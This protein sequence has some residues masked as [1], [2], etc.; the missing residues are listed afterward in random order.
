MRFDAA[1]RLRKRTWGHLT[2]PRALHERWSHLPW[3][4]LT[5]P[6]VSMIAH[7]RVFNVTYVG[8]MA[9]GR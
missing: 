3:V 4:R 7:I 6:C 2:P 5:R 1:E 8:I 9:R